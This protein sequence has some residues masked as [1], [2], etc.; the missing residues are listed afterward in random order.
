MMDQRA[1]NDQY[2]KDHIKQVKFKL[3]KNLDADLI[4]WIE[5][6]ENVNAYLK[7]L[8]SEDMKKDRQ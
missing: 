1:Y 6:Q 7:R 8:V 5:S 3:N 2:Q 4:D